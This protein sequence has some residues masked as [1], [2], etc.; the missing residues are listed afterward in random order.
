MKKIKIIAELK[1]FGTKENPVVQGIPEKEDYHFVYLFKS[2]N[3]YIG[4]HPLKEDTYGAI[5]IM[6]KKAKIQKE[7]E[8]N[9]VMYGLG[10]AISCGAIDLPIPKDDKLRLKAL[11]QI[12]KEDYSIEV[13]NILKKH[14]D[15]EIEN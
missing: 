11:I 4:K 12:E 14:I 5:L 2:N 9:K 13:I 8:F 1:D 3:K 6:D 10:V 7:E 15:L